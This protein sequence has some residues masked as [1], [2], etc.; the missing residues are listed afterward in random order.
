MVTNQA[1]MGAVSASSP[2]D[3]APAVPPSGATAPSEPPPGRPRWRERIRLTLEVIRANPTGRI[4]LKVF[5]GVAG[6]LVVALGAALIPL[7]GPGWLIV[8]GGIGIWAIEFSW[9]R[10]L[11]EF[12]RRNLRKWTGW[13]TRQ[14]WPVRLLLGL[15]GMIFVGAVVWLTVRFSFGID[16]VASVLNY[17]ATH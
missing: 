6:L 10:K 1:A 13:V 4:A 12:T 15:V 9:A 7:P 11:L 8:L 3:A 2:D 14:S 5:I 17:I 16:L